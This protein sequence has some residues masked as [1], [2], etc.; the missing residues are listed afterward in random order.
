MQQISR[1]VNETIVVNFSLQELYSEIFPNQQ[2]MSHV[3][4]ADT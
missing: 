3:Q 4:L 1:N 2:E